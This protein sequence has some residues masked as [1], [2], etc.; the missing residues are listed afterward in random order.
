MLNKFLISVQTSIFCELSKSGKIAIIGNMTKSKIWTK[1]SGSDTIRVVKPGHQSN[2]I[3]RVVGRDFGQS[4]KM[5][6]KRET[7]KFSAM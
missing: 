1:G 6:I 5:H 2:V 7:I 4:S 3:I